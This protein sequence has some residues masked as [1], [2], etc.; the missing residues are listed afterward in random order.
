MSEIWT[1][2]GP[3]LLVAGVGLLLYSWVGTNRR[4]MGSLPAD[5]G[6][7]GGRVVCEIVE[8]EGRLWVYR[9]DRLVP[10]RTGFCVCKKC[11]K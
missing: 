8:L 4:V 1:D 11:V 7:R 9:G 6:L 3:L 10:L 2:W 5:V